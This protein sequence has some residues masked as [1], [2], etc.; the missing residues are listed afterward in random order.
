M[1]NSRE[2]VTEAL[3]TDL[4]Y[5]ASVKRIEPYGIEH[6]PST[7]RNGKPYTQFTTWMSASLTLS[8]LVLGFFPTALGL[9]VMQSLSAVLVGALLGSLL[10]GVA[11]V[12]GVRLG[13]AIQVQARGPLGYVGNLVPVSLVNV[14]ASIGWTTVNCVFASIAFQQAF[15]AP[16]WVGA[17]V[18]LV[19]IGALAVWGYNLLHLVNKVATVLLAVLFIVIT[20]LAMQ[21]ADWSYPENPESDG[22]IG[23]IGGWITAVGF[24]LSWFLAWSPFASDFARYLPVR[25][26]AMRVGLFTMLGNFIPAVW[27]VSVGVLV[28][29]TAGALGP[30]EAVAEL[31]G[32][33]SPLAMI[34]LIVGALPT[35]GLTVY[36]GALSV[37][38][39]GV[40][41]KREV[42]ALV[43]VVVSFVLVLAFQNNIYNAFYDFLLISGYL[44]APYM[45]VVLI[46][47][48]YGPR[49]DISRLP[50]IFDR[51]R[52]F[53]AGFA[54]WLIGVLCSMP[55]WISPLMTGFVV[56]AAPQIGEVS[57]Y[58]GAGASAV[59]MVVFLK[60][61]LFDRPV[62]SLRG[63]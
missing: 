35:T 23:S 34:A 63:R 1:T 43:I 59:A 9:S 40:K 33:W 27:L 5:G 25:T 21:R 2:P 12:M 38:T 31:T 11:A 55:F 42:A 32:A 13:V 47:Y 48:Y 14:F 8:L 60:L 29:N 46:D 50:E 54:A 18:L 52:R 17:V 56:S 26:S 10:M 15:G 16:Y 41:V 19:V 28:A 20:V 7:D 58:V 53:A 44:I 45:A 39:L 57:Y 4:G 30:V 62:T 3:S 36:G 51:K 22:Y 37:L 6:I 49:R 24:V 61:G